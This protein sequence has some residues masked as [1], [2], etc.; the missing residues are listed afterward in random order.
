MY[1][2]AALYEDN[3]GGLCVFGWTGDTINPPVYYQAFGPE[4]IGDACADFWDIAA[5]LD[6]AGVGHSADN[7]KEA[8]EAWGY[9][10]DHE[11]DGGYR[12]V[13]D[14]ADFAISPDGDGA[15]KEPDAVLARYLGASG[16]A[17][18]F[19]FL[20]DDFTEEAANGE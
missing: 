8:G 16:R 3:A 5:N 9:V 17:A 6:G 2:Y 13:V 15:L 20:P 11:A 7:P 12:L 18:V 14:S 4:E 19:S 1:E 10:T